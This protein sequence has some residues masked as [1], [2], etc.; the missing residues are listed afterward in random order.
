MYL[1][2]GLCEDF[3]INFQDAVFDFFIWKTE[4]SEKN[5]CMYTHTKKLI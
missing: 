5:G 1:N 3:L 2:Q 4:G